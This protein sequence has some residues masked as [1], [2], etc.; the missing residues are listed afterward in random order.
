MEGLV[1]ERESKQKLL[2][3]D[4]LHKMLEQ[5]AWLF[6]EEFSLAGSEQRLEDVL[7]KHLA[8]LGPREDDIAPVDVAGGKQGRVDLMLS[9]TIRPRSG[10]YDYLVVELKRPSKKIDSDVLTQIEKYAIAVAGDER[11]RGVPARWTFVAISNDLD[12]YA[13]K[14][15]SQRGMPKG[16]V[17]DDAENNVTV[18]V[19]PWADVINDARSKLD[20]VNEQL[21]YE[22]D[23]DSAKAYLKKTHARFIPDVPAY[24][25]ETDRSAEEVV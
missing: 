9:K 4:Q 14:K 7:A 8:I 16:C 20:F 2:E 11:F 18:W 12:E 13:I 22:A 3:R 10:Q 1:F 6:H 5:E 25:E 17:Y 24:S 15:A 23:K 21:S 19:K